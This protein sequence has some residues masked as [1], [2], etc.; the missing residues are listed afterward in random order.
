MD[1]NKYYDRLN[2]MLNENLGVN[3]SAYKADPKSHRKARLYAKQLETRPEMSWSG[4][5]TVEAPDLPKQ[6]GSN[7]IDAEAFVKARVID[8]MS[9]AQEKGIEMTHGEAHKIASD[10]L[11]KHMGQD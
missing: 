6:S 2:K 11:K 7:D 1:H 5:S 9:K 10:M 3:F 4:D 8:M